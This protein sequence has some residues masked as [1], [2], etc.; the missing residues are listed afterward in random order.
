MN[1][2]AR[3]AGPRFAVRAARRAGVAAALLLALVAA[4][5][6][7]D[8]R[9]VRVGSTTSMADTGLLDSLL[10]DFERR[11]PGV[12]VEVFAVGSGEALALGRRGD[13]DAVIVHSPAAEDR[14]LEEGHG[15]D[16]RRFAR[17]DFVLA[18]PPDDPAG[19][20]GLGAVEAFRAIATTGTR[21][22]SRGDDSGTHAREWRIWREAGVTPAGPWYEEVGQGMSATLLVADERSACALTD[23]ATYVTLARGLALEPMVEDD[24]L[25]E[26]LYAVIRVT[27]AA[28]PEDAK[29][30]ADWLTAPETLERLGQFGV[31][32]YGAPL[33]RPLEP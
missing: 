33:F 9:V 16:R 1:D 14:F 25:L 28:H 18:C 15:I 24:P 17:N 29:R 12:R 7:P 21:F 2:A 32:E 23:R 31:E 4:C 13:V 19:V 5:S 3:H 26:N 11:T 20:R 8:D 22:V 6:A 10:V 27:T 30:F